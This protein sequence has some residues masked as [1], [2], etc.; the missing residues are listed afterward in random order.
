M[1]TLK[2]YRKVFS[3]QIAQHDGRI[4]NAPGDSILTEFSSVANTVASAEENQREITERKRGFV[5]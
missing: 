3:S 2:A 5:P 4:V 1:R